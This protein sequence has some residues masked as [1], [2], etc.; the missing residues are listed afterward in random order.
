[1]ATDGNDPDEQYVVICQP[2]PYTV[3]RSPVLLIIFSAFS[4]LE[5]LETDIFSLVIDDVVCE[6]LYIVSSAF[7]HIYPAFPYTC[8]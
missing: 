3:I 7:G 6:F 1:M 4:R 8:K 2:F 5:T